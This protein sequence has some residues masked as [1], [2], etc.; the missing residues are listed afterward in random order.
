MLKSKDIPSSS[1]SSSEVVGYSSSFFIGLSFR[2][3]LTLGCIDV[4]PAIEEFV[5]HV[6]NWENKKLGMDLI[7]SAHTKNTI[8]AFVYNTAAAPSRTSGCTPIRST[9]NQIKHNLAYK[10][11]TDKMA[12]GNFSP[13]NNS[14]SI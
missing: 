4:N 13:E 3:G 1:F 9:T 11:H 14:S 6:N 2:S 8:P 7:I 5:E 12:R 10:E